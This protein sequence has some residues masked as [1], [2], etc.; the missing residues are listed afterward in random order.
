MSMTVE[1]I[2]RSITGFLTAAALATGCASRQ[3]AQT[4]YGDIHE[5]ECRVD[6]DCSKGERCAE[7]RAHMRTSTGEI[8]GDDV[9][10]WCEP[11]ADVR[12]PPPA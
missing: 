6:D 8:V 3:P 2:V 5:G 11:V 4:D 9:N 12:E 10:H 1:S 7:S